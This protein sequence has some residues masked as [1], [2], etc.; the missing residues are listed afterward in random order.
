LSGWASLVLELLICPYSV[1]IAELE[2]NPR[3]G[4]IQYRF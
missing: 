1:R 3:N 4:R 2:C